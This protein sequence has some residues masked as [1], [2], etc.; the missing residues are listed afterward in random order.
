MGRYFLQRLL[1]VF[2]TVIGVTLI[3]FAL[4]RLVP[5]GVESALL[6]QDATPEKVHA[7]R[8]AL[9]LD[10]PLW[11]QYVTW[12]GHAARG[13]LGK[14][15]FQG[16]SVAK[17]IKTRI[18]WTFELGGFALLFSILIALPVGI[19]A[20]IRQDSMLD[21]LAR[22]FAIF[23]LSAP[24]FVLATLLIVYGS[25]GL[26][27]GGI[28]LHFTP[29]LGREIGN[30]LSL[31]LQLIIP[32]ALILGIVLSGSVMRLTRTQMLEVMRQ[33]YIRTARAKGLATGGVIM[34]HALRNAFIPV[35]TIIGLQV[36]VLVGGSVILEQIFSLPG[37]GFYLLYAIGQRDFTVIQGVVVV[38]ATIV[39]LT[40]LLTDLTYSL[41]DPR[42][43]SA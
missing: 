31:N 22:S 8:H 4:V 28:Y 21:Y 17:D 9:G 15:I 41:L 36:P 3:L 43:R 11:K 20:A 30:S 14:S 2:P 39:I 37:M 38:S 34:G 40:N 5:G 35:V 25:I 26:H 29:P 7:I 13:D 1:L 18:G 32:P 24:S 27:V 10:Q 16:T 23:G 12:A 33:D 6:G 19:L 42:I